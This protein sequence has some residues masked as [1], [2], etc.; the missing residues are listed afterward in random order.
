[1]KEM[2]KLSFL[3]PDSLKL[4]RNPSQEISQ[5]LIQK[6]QLLLLEL[7][8][9]AL[10]KQIDQLKTSSSQSVVGAESRAREFELKLKTANSRIQELESQNRSLELQLKNL[11]G[12]DSTSS[13]NTSRVDSNLA[14]S[15][16][17]SS[18][19]SNRYGEG[20]TYGT[21]SGQ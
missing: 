19:S 20:A 9:P 17:S 7:K 5:E 4:K 16:Y 13:A 21:T 14:S 2:L 11:G 15:Q 18:S 1:V 10:S 12:K 8:T 6:E 3:R